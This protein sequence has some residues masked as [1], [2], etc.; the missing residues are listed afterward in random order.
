MATPNGLPSDDSTQEGLGR[1]IDGTQQFN[2][3]DSLEPSHIGL[4]SQNPPGWL[5]RE[6]DKAHAPVGPGEMTKL[7]A[8][9]DDNS[10]SSSSSIA[11]EGR[12]G[13]PGRQ[14]PTNS[15]K[16][17]SSVSI[18][19]DDIE[20]PQE[21]EL[22]KSL[23]KTSTAPQIAD[24]NLVTWAADDPDNPKTWSARLKWTCV[25]IVSIFTFISPVS[26]S[27]T[28]RMCDLLLP[29]FCHTRM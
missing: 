21:V 3:G 24:P 26:S 14:S 25:A 19:R 5:T 15:L 1:S 11:E 2:D 8:H 10:T 9:K 6:T 22:R 27:M 7:E 16:V 18:V 4:Q 29:L 13:N 12:M 23:E 17:K 20:I 28:A